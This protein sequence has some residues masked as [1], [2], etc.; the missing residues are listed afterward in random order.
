MIKSV[1]SLI[2]INFKILCFSSS[3]SEGSSELTLRY[4]N[5][6]LELHKKYE[7]P[8]RPERPS[9]STI[10]EFDPLFDSSP[11]SS[12]QT[13]TETQI[14]NDMFQLD[15][16]GTNSNFE[17]NYDALSISEESEAGEEFL[18]PPTPPQRTDSLA[19][20]GTSTS[21]SNKKPTW[22]TENENPESKPR[23]STF[24]SKLNDMLKKVP[25]SARHITVG[26]Q[27]DK[28]LDRPSLNSRALYQHKGI[29][30][31]ISSKSVE[32][33]FGEFHFRWLVLSG[34]AMVFYADNA[35]ENS[36]EQ[37]PLE[38]ILSVQYAADKKY[39]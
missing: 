15:L 5:Y 6:I 39:K 4:E 29:L 17:A 20:E 23:S 13:S 37:I 12:V 28:F 35:C 24:F 34:G 14:L 19:E 32:D 11:S 38:T 8:Q 26:L 1:F 9:K 31:R 30:F 16:Y 10:L 25:E 21:D 18:N 36:K 3:D 33:L 27:K 7:I 22:Y 2:E